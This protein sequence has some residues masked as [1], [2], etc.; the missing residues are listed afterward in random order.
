MQEFE[1]LNEAAAK[2]AAAAVEFARVLGQAVAAAFEKIEWKSI[3]AVAA[4]EMAYAKAQQDR[5]EWVHRAN[6]SKKKRIR[7][8][9]HDRIMRQYG[10]GG[11]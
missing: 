9:Y 4:Y 7:K 10:R 6:N 8:K 5:P 11:A 1:E 3:C 2:V